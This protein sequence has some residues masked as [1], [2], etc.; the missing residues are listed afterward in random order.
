MR[1]DL[2]REAR[3]DLDDIWTYIAQ[4]SPAAANR[5][6]EKFDQLMKQLAFHPLMGAAREELAENLRVA[7][8]G[9]YLVFYRPLETRVLVVRVLHGHRDLHA[10]L[11]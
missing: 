2:S 6:L 5:V 7:V 8:S 9:S 3:R 10:D 4:D 11:F 1:L